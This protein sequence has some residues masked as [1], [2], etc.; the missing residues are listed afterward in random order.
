MTE[1][2]IDPVSA[3]DERLVLAD[4]PLR[5]G[6]HVAG[7]SRFGDPSWDLSPAV[8]QHHTGAVV[9]HFDRVPPRYR[10]LVKQL[11]YAL[12]SAPPPPGEKR[13]SIATVP[14][15]VQGVTRFLT[16]LLT[17]S[18]S[19]RG[20]PGPAIA[21]LA[22][23]D[24]VAYDQHLAT[25]DITAAVR[26][27]Y[28]LAVGMLWRYRTHLDDG[29]TVDPRYIAAWG[30]KPVTRIEN[31]TDRIPEPV[32]GPLLAWALRFVDEFAPDILAALRAREE[33]QHRLDLAEGAGIDI[34]QV[35][36][37]LAD[38]LGDLLARREPVP[39]FNGRP[40]TR[41]ISA[42]VRCAPYRFRATP[43]LV[44][45]LTAAIEQV[46][47]TEHTW[48]TRK[49]TGKLDDRPWLEGIAV[50]HPTQSVDVL[51]RHLQT[52]CHIVV[53]F[54]SGM[55]DSELKHIRRG[56]V[57]ARRDTTGAVYRW[58]LTSLVFKGQPDPA[59]TTATWI[60][61]AP[62]ARA[63]AVLEQLQ[64]P[65][66]DLLL[67]P[68][69]HQGAKARSAVV[70]TSTSN[71]RFN[72][73]VDWIN[74]YCASRNRDDDVPLVNGVRFVLSSRQFRRTLAWFIARRPGGTIAGAIQYKHHGIQMFE[75]YAGTSRSGFR[76]EVESEQALLRGEQ[77][78]QMA[79]DHEHRHL[80][81]PAA[82]EAT[83]RL[84]QFGTDAR[85]AGMIL[86]DPTR[87]RRYLHRHEP[88]VYPG[89]YST[90][91]FTPGKALC[92]PQYGKQG[93]LL[94]VLSRCRPLDCG[95][96][97]LTDTNVAALTYELDRIDQ[98]LNRRPALP[99]LPH[100]QLRQRRNAIR[101][102]L[103]QHTMET[104]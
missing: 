16:W 43:A 34:D 26:S 71:V 32:L 76:A 58:V 89:T 4:R 77:L 52:A 27:R 50:L 69:S 24:L 101:R 82:D 47:I 22:A 35:S 18:A 96:V 30:K 59:G 100:Q 67:A 104:S 61:G 73:F 103:G 66:Q 21:T 14:Q 10:S 49:I 57:T 46:G 79:T 56:S 3:L 31:S 13:Q 97:A 62:A 7:T 39:G 8:L 54:L 65:Q 63:V 91:V 80:T 45:Q 72:A 28:R 15:I 94:P 38:Y 1:P 55:R 23:S 93:T 87:V 90:C 102:L 95:N 81:G 25:R 44:Q 84:Q 40:N 85:Y 88:N 75:G 33:Y 48:L 6:V 99:P 9:V 5:D 29:L 37:R 83:R 36:D 19:H 98:Q 86:A 12:L 41:F 92:Q 60:I 74:D 70:T 78:L 53:A 42:Q 68:L 20:T 51:A 11:C 64:P 2:L 17:D